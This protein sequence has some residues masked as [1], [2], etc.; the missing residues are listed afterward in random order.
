VRVAMGSSVPASTCSVAMSSSVPPCVLHASCTPR[1]SCLEQ[2]LICCHV[3]VRCSAA[4]LC[5]KRSCCA[6]EPLHQVFIS[7]GVFGKGLLPQ[8]MRPSEI[9]MDSK[10]FAKLMKEAGVM[11]QAQPHA[12]RPDLHQ[13]L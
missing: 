6:A 12:R 11:E 7:F 13:V 10:A 9:R 2:A 1:A 4:V 3:R 5:L 8:D